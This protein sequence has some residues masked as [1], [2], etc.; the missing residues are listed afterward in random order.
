MCFRV[1]CATVP[2]CGYNDVIR[3]GI[4]LCLFSRIVI[5][6]SL[7]YIT[8]LDIGSRPYRSASFVFC[9]V[10]HDLNTIRKCLVIPVVIFSLL[11]QLAHL[12][13]SV[14]FVAIRVQGAE[15]LMITFSNL[16]A[17]AISSS[18]MKTCQKGWSL[19]VHTISLSLWSSMCYL[20]QWV[21]TVRIQG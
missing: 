7:R 16:V 5:G 10:E 21:L 12:A 18:T 1:W 3:S 13:G 17:C 20:Q 19:Q 8:C 15:W 9:L 14:I 2:I 6:S 11:N 4:L